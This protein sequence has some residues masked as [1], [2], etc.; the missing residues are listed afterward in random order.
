M[1]YTAA[2][3]GNEI[4][5]P[6]PASASYDCS[7]DAPADSFEGIFPSEKAYGNITGIRIYNKGGSL[8]FDG[9]TDIEKEISGGTSYISLTA[10]NRAGLLLDSEPLPQSYTY[11]SLP[12]IYSR[13]VK[14]YGFTGYI[15]SKQ[16][17]DGTVTVTKGMSEWQVVSAYCKHFLLVTPRVRGSILDASGEKPR[18]ETVFCNPGGICYSSAVRKNRYCDMYSELFAPSE[19]SG[20]YV[21]MQKDSE[22]EAL[23]ILRKRCLLSSNTDAYSLIKKTDRKAFSLTVD[24]PG[25]ILA[26]LYSPASLKDQFLGNI[27]GLY[28]SEIH[29]RLDTSGEHCKIVLRKQ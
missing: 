10:R 8:F 5:L 1:I 2:V 6:A 15:G 24:C 18:D 23:G 28:V 25:G 26:E 20:T 17:H 29:Y 3:N 14:P 9:V 22:T 13:H 16:Q 11:P 4:S 12:V 21:S 27:G 19:T 7:E